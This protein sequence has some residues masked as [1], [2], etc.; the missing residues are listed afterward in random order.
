MAL[1]LSGN[2]GHH[3]EVAFLVESAG[4]DVASEAVDGS[5]HDLD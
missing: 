4:G 1:I 2:Q 5:A 3:S